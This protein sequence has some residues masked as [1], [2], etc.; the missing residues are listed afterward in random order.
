[1][2]E[3]SGVDRVHRKRKAA[4]GEGRHPCHYPFELRLKAVKLYL[5][6]G[7]SQV[8][9][10]EQL[11]FGKK[12][13]VDWVKRYRELGEEGLRSRYS[14]SRSA[15]IPPAVRHKITELK[16]RYPTFGV[17]RIAQL[18]RRVFFLSASRETV[19]RTLH[20]QNLILKKRKA[21]RSPPKPRFF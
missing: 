8:W 3:G 19:R 2:E 5:E 21:K 13:L 11:G 20:Q 7:Y 1:M 4:R 12:T 15:K 14:G 9:I 6:E 10:S 18:L 17:K 16:R